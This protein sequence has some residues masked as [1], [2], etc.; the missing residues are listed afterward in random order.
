VKTR[1]VTE[2]RRVR[3]AGFAGAEI[4]MTPLIDVVLVLLIVFMVLTPLAEREIML[5]L[6]TG[7]TAEKGSDPRAEQLVVEL[8]ADGS[9]FIN[10][11]TA[12]TKDYVALLSERLARRAADDQVVFFVASDDA[13]YGALVSLMDG[14]RQAGA[15]IIGF[16]PTAR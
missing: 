6:P 1:S 3:T 12:P 2:V 10:G 9:V 14:A 4:N 5:R 15:V 11:A 13:G 16:A 7:E 8:G